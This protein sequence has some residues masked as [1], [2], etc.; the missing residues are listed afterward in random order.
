MPKKFGRPTKN[1]AQPPTCRGAPSLGE[2]KFQPLVAEGHCCLLLRCLPQLSATTRAPSTTAPSPPHP[3]HL[4]L[5]GAPPS[6]PS[7]QPP[8]IRNVCAAVL[9]PLLELLHVLLWLPVPTLPPLHVGRAWLLQVATRLLRAA[10]LL[11]V[12]QSIPKVGQ[13]KA[14]DNRKVVQGT[15]NGVGRKNN[16]S[17]PDM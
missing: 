6:V 17:P 4:F 12:L 8:P 10:A 9:C 1:Q 7:A 16:N 15:A 3:C 14:M 2:L 11:N 13:S 5:Q